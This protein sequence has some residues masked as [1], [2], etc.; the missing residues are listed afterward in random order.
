VEQG[1]HGHHD[2]VQHHLWNGIFVKLNST[3]P[4]ERNIPKN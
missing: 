2:S 3:P 1:D 4:M